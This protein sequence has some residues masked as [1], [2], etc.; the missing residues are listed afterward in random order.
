MKT[1]GALLAT[2]VAAVAAVW[3]APLQDDAVASAS[4]CGSG[5][6]GPKGYGYAGHESI[7]VASGV[8]ATITQLRA[9]GV[10]A[11]HAAAWIGVGGPGAGPKGETMWLQAGLAALPGHARHALRGDHARRP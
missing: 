2:V 8:R 4:A 3:L 6:H 7:R 10:P 11:G 1:R 9:P 5:A